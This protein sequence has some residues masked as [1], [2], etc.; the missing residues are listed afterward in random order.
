MV[1]GFA[2]SVLLSVVPIF[3]R[4]QAPGELL[5][6]H[7]DEVMMTHLTATRSP[8]QP[9]YQQQSRSCNLL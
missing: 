4:E 1:D 5:C 8:L 6:L 9:D 7:E 3:L 2:N